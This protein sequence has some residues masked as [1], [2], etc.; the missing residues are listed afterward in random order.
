[1]RKIFYNE[2]KILMDQ[3]VFFGKGVFE[4][5][6]C[7]KE[8]S[9]MEEHLKRLKYSMDVIGLEPLEEEML[10]EFLKSI[11]RKNKALKITVTPLNIIITEREIPYKEEDYKTG[12]KLNFSKVRRNSTSNLTYIK[13]I[14]Y[15]ENLLEKEKATKLGFNDTIFLNEKGYITETSCSNIFLI[16]NNEIFTPRVQDGLLNGIIRGWIVENCEVFEKSIT[17]KDIEECDEVFITNSLMGIMPIVQIENMKYNSTNYT[18]IIRKKFNEAMT[19][20]GG[21]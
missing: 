6:H 15:L 10:R 8:P 16:K 2:E 20:V 13:S 12:F 7:A 9:L 1:M 18:K 21:I 3:G 14:G 5:I 4:T 17:I 19:E 11:P